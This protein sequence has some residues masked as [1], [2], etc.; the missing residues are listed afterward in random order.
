MFKALF[1]SRLQSMWFSLFA[2]NRL[3]TGGGNKKSPGKKVLVGILAV[4]ILGTFGVMFIGIFSQFAAAFGNSEY[5]WLYFSFAGMFAFLLSVVGSVFMT[6]KQLFEAKDNEL[7]LSMPIPSSYIVASRMLMLLCVNLMYTM[8]VIVPAML[9]FGVKVGF[10]A[11]TLI[12]SIIGIVL[13]PLLSMAVECLFAWLIALIGTK[14]K[15][16][17]A[18]S[19]VLYIVFFG[20][21]MWFFMR[22]ENNIATL[23]TNG[24]Q[25]GEAI[26]KYMPPL[27]AF[28]VSS[29]SGDIVRL[30]ELAL[31]CI[32]PFAL[33]YFAIS[34]SFIKIST[35]SK[36]Q[37]RK[38]YVRTSLEV[39]S[40]RKALL[41][42]ELSR[43]FSLPMYM[44]NSGLGAVMAPAIFILALFKREELMQS[45]VAGADV[46]A[47][48]P[49]VPIAIIA[50][51]VSTLC[52]SAPSLS[53]EG[54]NFWVLKTSPVSAG[55]VF[56][57]KIMTN[58]VI[59]LPPMVLASVIGGIAFT[60]TPLQTVLTVVFTAFMQILV[61]V[62]GFIFNLHFP[63]FEWLNE[64]L[65]IKQSI[66]V[67]LTMFGSMALAAAAIVISVLLYSSPK[68]NFSVDAGLAVCC[69]FFAI[70][71]A[72]AYA[73]LKTA[74]V[75]VYDRL[76]G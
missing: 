40:P 41:K 44:L 34:K 55:D 65:V 11:K 5:A 23:I 19:M 21:Y 31:W 9:T 51:C 26:G 75:K 6:Q 33:M 42:K 68:F 22:L 52:T 64:T 73:Y 48:L 59:G 72:V 29:A 38:V 1:I 39:T 43:F 35:S 50:F 53:L 16:K 17:N 18:A 4:Y 36:T 3:K 76:N 62:V 28:G 61:A 14:I 32:V 57:A 74:G 60:L 13:M 49:F 58:I 56:Y 37:D 30:G 24:T 69:A 47:Y 10:S 2:S 70:L 71:D 27:Y 67:I 7:L 25:I 66:P 46:S 12:F 63:K 15:K 45:L 20:A 54:K 8:L